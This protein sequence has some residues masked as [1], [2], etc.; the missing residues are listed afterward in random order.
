[1]PSCCDRTLCTDG[2]CVVYLHN[3]YDSVYVRKM[4]PT[5]IVCHRSQP[6]KVGRRQIRFIRCVCLWSTARISNVCHAHQTWVGLVVIVLQTNN[7]K[8]TY[9]LYREGSTAISLPPLYR[10]G[11]G[12]ISFG[13][14]AVNRGGYIV[15]LKRFLYLIFLHDTGEYVNSLICELA[16]FIW[17][18]SG[19]DPVAFFKVLN[20]MYFF[21]RLAATQG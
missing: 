10:Y 5:S 19:V 13:S 11:I 14:T 3:R 15:R 9:G 4:L 8:K 21:L 16:C 12:S 17:K 7:K 1:M 2:G 18:E 20:S 6:I